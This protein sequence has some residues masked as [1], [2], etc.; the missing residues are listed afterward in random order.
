M[1]WIFWYRGKNDAVKILLHGLERLEY[2][3]YDSAWVFVKKQSWDKSRI[4]AVG[5]VSALNWKVTD[6]L[7][8]WYTQWIAHT[9]RATHGGV[10]EQ[11]THPHISNDG[12]RTIVHNGIVENYASIKKD[13]IKKWYRFDSET[14]TEV[15]ANLLEEIHKDSKSMLETTQELQKQIRWAYALL[16][17]HEGTPDTMIALRLWSPLVYAYNSEGEQYFSSDT[18][19]LSGYADKMIYLEDGDLIKVQWNDYTI[20][21][22]GDVTKRDIETFDQKI[23]EASKGEYKHFMLKEIYEQPAIIKRIYKWRVS[24]ENNSLHADAFHGM[25]N[26]SIKQITT[27]AC[28]TANNAGWLWTY[29]FE[30]LSKIPSHNEIASEYENKPF[31]LDES[32]LHIFVSQSGETADSLEVLKMLKEQGGKSF[33]VVNVVGSSIARMTDSGLYLRAGT[34]IWVASTKAFMAQSMCLLLVSLFLGKRRGMRLSKYQ[35]IMRE[36]EHL[37]SYIETVLDQTDHIRSIAMDLMQ[38]KNFFFLWRG[39]QYPIAAESSLK[40]KEI[41][42]LHSEA[43]GAG[44]LK[45][46]SLAL[47]S[48]EMPTIFNLPN[49]E[50]FEQNLSNFQ[51]IRARKGKICVIGDKRVEEADR[52]IT[53]PETIDEIYPF[54]TAVAGQLLAYHVADLLGN[55]IDKPRNLAKSVTVK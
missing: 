4:R 15:V 30:T 50:M 28:G 14:D 26:E 3:G 54:L 2:R 22:N 32:K 46:G 42:Y 20:L 40:F 6:F 41:T 44:E 5:K 1:C 38:Y 39:Y 45:H 23:L 35:Q 31:F 24:F 52:Q 7:D 19:A 17:M 47:I 13:L 9:R 53:I 34:E 51:E 43:Y 16:I 49:D 11:N 10:T 48:E 21:S 8:A 33:G 18:Q 27:V 37:P 25:G 55:D 29:R 36:L 12:N